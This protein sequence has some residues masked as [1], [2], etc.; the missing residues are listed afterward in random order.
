[1]ELFKA[2]GEVK[3]IEIEKIQNS[4]FLKDQGIIFLM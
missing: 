4:E 2:I 1:M 3:A